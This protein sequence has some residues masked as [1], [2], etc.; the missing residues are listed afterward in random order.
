MIGKLGHEKGLAHLGSA[1]KEICPRIEQ[2]VYHR[3]SAGV[4]LFVEVI[5]RHGRQIGRVIDPAYLPQISSKSLSGGLC[6]VTPSAILWLGFCESDCP[7]LRQQAD[8]G[9]SFLSCNLSI[10][11]S[12][13]MPSM[14]AAISRMVSSNSPST[15]FPASIR[16]SS[17]RTAASSFRRALYTLGLPCTTTSR[18]SSRRVM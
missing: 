13:L 6:S 7:R 11:Q 1:H 2:T 16:S 18:H 12:S 8:M 9:Q 3:R 15:P 4:H 10:Y 17:S 14:M 5:H